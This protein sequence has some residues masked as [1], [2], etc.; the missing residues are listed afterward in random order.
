MGADMGRGLPYAWPVSEYIIAF[1]AINADDLDDAAVER[2]A[3]AARD[4]PGTRPVGRVLVDPDTR[5]IQ[6]S[7]AIGV[8]QAMA[9]A[10]RD[11]GRLA[12]EL[13][14]AARMP[15]ARLVEM[16]VRMVDPEN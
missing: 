13:L 10:A 4:M 11:G 3:Q 6:A 7:F 16:T 15:D 5:R 2:L 12:K 1:T 14:L 9:E 8:E